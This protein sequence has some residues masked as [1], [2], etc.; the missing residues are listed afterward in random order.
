MNDSFQMEEV[1]EEILRLQALEALFSKYDWTLVF[2]LICVGFGS[3]PTCREAFRSSKT[4]QGHKNHNMTNVIQM[5]ETGCI[6][7]NVVVTVST[8]HI[9]CVVE[10]RNF[11]SEK[12][13]AILLRK[14]CKRTAVNKR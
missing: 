9:R 11:I 8:R 10:S 5:W 4:G 3:Q 7:K 14:T 2:A 13:T 6:A 12:K 1:F